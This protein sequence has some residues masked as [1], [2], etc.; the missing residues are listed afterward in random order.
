MV[1]LFGSKSR[2]TPLSP[3]EATNDSMAASAADSF[4]VFAKRDLV[5]ARAGRDRHVDLLGSRSDL[6]QVGR[7]EAVARQF[8]RSFARLLSLAVLH[9]P[10]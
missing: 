6:S 7:A 9:V 8:G 3:F 10:H 5:G 1:Q 4:E 2:S